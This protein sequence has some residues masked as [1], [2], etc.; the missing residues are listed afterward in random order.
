MADSAN[1]PKLGT[2]DVKKVDMVLDCVDTSVPG[3]PHCACGLQVPA[4]CA[5]Y[6]PKAQGSLPWGGGYGAFPVRAPASGV[7]HVPRTMR[8]QVLREMEMA[9]LFPPMFERQR[10]LGRIETSQPTS[11]ASSSSSLT[12]GSRRARCS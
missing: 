12:N 9:G 3:L 6:V 5:L 7:P 4:A 11:R 10:S 2:E 8:P 1:H